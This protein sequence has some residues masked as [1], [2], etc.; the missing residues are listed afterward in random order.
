MKLSGFLPP[1]RGPE[2]FAA[3]KALSETIMQM[4]LGDEVIKRFVVDN[5]KGKF[6]YRHS[7]EGSQGVFWIHL[8]AAREEA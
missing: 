4:A 8:P 3:Q 7:R 2:E 6:Y 1:D 5:H